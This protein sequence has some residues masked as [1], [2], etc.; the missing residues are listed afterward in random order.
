MTD[1]ERTFPLELTFRELEWFD[2]LLHEHVRNPTEWRSTPAPK[3]CELFDAV[4]TDR[5][6]EAITE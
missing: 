4:L 5:Y 3:V 2:T 1:P 6:M